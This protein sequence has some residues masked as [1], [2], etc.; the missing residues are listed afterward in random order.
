MST[1]YTVTLP[2]KPYV[3]KYINTIEGGEQIKFDAKN[4][5]CMIIRAYLENSNK[6]GLNSQDMEAHLKTRNKQIKIIVP[7]KRMGDVGHTIKPDNAV[8]INRFLEDVFKKAFISFVK[9]FTKKE[10]RY[11]DY[12]DAYY[13]FAESYKIVIDED[14]TFDALQKM[15]YRS[16]QKKTK[17]NFPSFVHSLLPL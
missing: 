10:G 17:K 15:D 7:M 5:F 3:Q 4:M 14:I 13:A 8:L 9:D 2:V 6:C 1:T 11:R 12:K 16:R